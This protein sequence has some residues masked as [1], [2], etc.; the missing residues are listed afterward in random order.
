MYAMFGTLDM[1]KLSG[2][3]N[4]RVFCR[5]QRGAWEAGD[6]QSAGGRRPVGG[7]QGSMWGPSSWRIGQVRSRTA[8]IWYMLVTLEVSKVSGWLNAVAP[9]RVQREAC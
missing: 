9:Y 3:L 6:M 5:V 1:L 8:N 2:W 4:A 7:S